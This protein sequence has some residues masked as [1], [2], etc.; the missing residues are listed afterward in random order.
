MVRLIV[1]GF[2]VKLNF[3][4]ID[5]L[6]RLV[7]LLMICCIFLFIT[8]ILLLDSEKKGQGNC[9]GCTALQHREG[10]MLR[11]KCNA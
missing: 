3:L 11:E 7:S 2:R 5:S 8:Y 9:E 10:N 6:A 1:P 4:I